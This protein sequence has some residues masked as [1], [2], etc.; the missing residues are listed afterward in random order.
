M[1]ALGRRKFLLTAGAAAAATVVMPSVSP[2]W[3]AVAQTS[4]PYRFPQDFFWGAATAAAQ[5]EGSP[6]ADGGGDSIWDVFLR[7]P[8]ATKDGSN[9]LIADDEYHRWPE[10]IKLMREIGLNAYRFSISWPRVFPDGKS[11]NEK[12]LAY[13]SRLVDALL[14][15]GI[16]PFVT[17]YHFDYPEA[18]QKLGG[19]LHPD[20][21]EWLGHYAE[22]LSRR[23]SDRVEHWITINE[24]NILWGFGNEAG[25]MPPGKKLPEADLVRGAHNILLGHGKAVQG[26]RAGARRPVQ[27]TLAFAGMFSLPATRSPED[28]AAACAESFS[29]AKKQIIPNLPPMTMLSNAWWL[30]PIYVGSYPDD[31]VK[32]FPAAEKLAASADM[33]T[34]HEP[35][36]FCAVN[37]YSAP[38]V[39]ASANGTA[40]AVPDPPDVKRSHYGWAITPDLLYWAPRFLFDRYKK[41][42]AITENGVSLDDKPSAD[43]KVHDPDRT[44][45]VDAYLKKLREASQDGVPLK[46]YF[47]WSL[48]DNFEWTSGFSERFGLIYVDYPT[49]KRILKDSAM[50]YS[51]IIKSR[52][53]AL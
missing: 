1:S 10:D 48:L 49:Q 9:N 31:G 19:W 12:T 21:P 47:H 42:V 32:L 24:P 14:T 8:H 25:L 17:T 38:T 7:T 27:I 5:C 39:K 45:F 13:Y 50:R 18:L 46:G 34:I 36:D 6:S 35:L 44:A 15:A 20:S 43:G 23:F 11:V 51:Q 4:K 28:V 33:K 52:G 40:E 2:L 37:L 16:T 53:A 3:R 41:P 30:D 22:V 29:V 26:I